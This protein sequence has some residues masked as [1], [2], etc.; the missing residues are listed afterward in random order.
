MTRRAVSA[1][2]LRGA[3]DARVAGGARG[4][5]R[6]SHRPDDRG[7]SAIDDLPALGSLAPADRPACRRLAAAVARLRADRRHA[8]ARGRRF[9]RRRLHRAQRRRMGR[10]REG[11][12]SQQP[13]PRRRSSERSSAPREREPRQR[14]RRGNDAAASVVAK[15]V[16]GS[17][18]TQQLAKNVFLSGERNFLRKGQELVHRLRDGGFARQAAHPRDLPRQRRMGR[19]RVRRRSRGAALFRRRLRA[20]LS[21]AA[22]GPAGSH[23]A[24][25][26]AVREASGLRLCARHAPRRSPREWVRS[27][28]PEPP[29]SRQAR[30]S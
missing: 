1:A 16:G 5:L 25:A 8:Q 22:G 14:C 4:L 19:R 30:T 26:Q 11:V 13:A 7:R 28:C 12:G 21:A 6:P 18:I 17:T 3:A 24:G 23:A 29:R 20:Q 2:L 9:R 27:S 10:A 15:V